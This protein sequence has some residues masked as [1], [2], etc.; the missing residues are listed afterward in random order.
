MSPEAAVPPT[1][2]GHSPPRSPRGLLTGTGDEEETW[3]QPGGWGQRGAAFAVYAAGVGGFARGAGSVLRPGCLLAVPGRPVGR[4]EGVGPRAEAHPAAAPAPAPGPS[5][6][7]VAGELHLTPLRGILQLRPSFS[8]LDKADAKHREREAAHDGAPGPPSWGGPGGG[9]GVQRQPRPAPRGSGSSRPLSFEHQKVSTRPPTV[10]GGP[11]WE[12]LIC[13]RPSLPG[14]RG[15]ARDPSCGRGP[16]RA[17][18][19]RSRRLFAGRGGGGREADHG[20]PRCRARGAG[21]RARPGW[22]GP[23]AGRPP[24]LVPGSPGR[25]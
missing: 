13:T 25:T 11:S 10:P 21:C 1:S 23:E 4:W 24:T 8:Y 5:P 19:S 12:P 14:G 17:A 16:E 22:R 20:E 7:P 6:V 18:F 9:H 2:G 3:G 15:G